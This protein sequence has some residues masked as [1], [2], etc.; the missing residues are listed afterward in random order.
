MSHESPPGG[1][2]PGG[3]P[4]AQQGPAPIP[5]AR[6]AEVNTALNEAKAKHAATLH[7]LDGA[8]A[9]LATV[10]ALTQQVDE[11][12]AA[13]VGLELDRTMMQNGIMSDDGRAL[14]QWE[15]GRLPEAGRPALGDWLQTLRADPTKAAAHM[16]PYLPKP[17]AAPVAPAAAVPPAAAA[18]TPPAAALPPANNGAAGQTPAHAGPY[19]AADL[20]GMSNEDYA[21]HRK[22]ILAQGTVKLG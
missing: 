4:P 2:P 21:K 20:K 1:A 22:A 8:R 12:T 18:P 13:K 15:Y 17:P 14:A 19:T 10:D 7:E 16:R 3:Q 6:F 11:L 5:Y 9:R